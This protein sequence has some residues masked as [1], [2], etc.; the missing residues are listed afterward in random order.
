MMCLKSYGYFGM[1]EPKGSHISLKM[2][3]DGLGLGPE[4]FVSLAKSAKLETIGNSFGIIL[5]QS[6]LDKRVI[7]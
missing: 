7:N 5:E 1:A 3:R 6:R 2:S 4:G